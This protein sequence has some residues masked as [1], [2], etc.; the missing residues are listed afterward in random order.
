MAD[1]SELSPEV[2][3]ILSLLEVLIAARKLS[4]REIER[5]LNVSNGTLARLFS[6][7]ISLKFQHVLDLLEILDVTPK[8]FFRAGYSLDDPGAMKAEELLRQAQDL[9]FPNPRESSVPSRAEIVKMIE[10]ALAARQD[11]PPP[12]PRHPPGTP[13]KPRRP[14]PKKKS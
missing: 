13:R 3:R 10:D 1:P 7:K 4:I 8:A 2:S 12:K 9:A 6:G 14:R 5:R 11:P